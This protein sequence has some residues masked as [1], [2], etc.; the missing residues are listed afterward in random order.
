[1]PRKTVRNTQSGIADLP[2]DKPVVYEYLTPTGTVNYAGTAQRGR[3]QARLSEHLRGQPDFVP[4]AKIQIQQHSSIAEAR[5][6]EKA[7]IARSHPKYNK[8][9]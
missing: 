8:Q 2:N 3:V 5:K 9:G 6:Q 7:I 1:M 4:G